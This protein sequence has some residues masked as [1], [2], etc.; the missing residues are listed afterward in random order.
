[1]CSPSR[2]HFPANE[3]KEYQANT[4]A[5][6][7]ITPTPQKQIIR[8]LDTGGSFNTEYN[9]PNNGVLFSVRTE[10]PTRLIFYYF[11]ISGLAGD[12]SGFSFSPRVSSATD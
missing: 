10:I 12:R 3:N 6:G 5:D 7:K 1:M 11:S 8:N 2:I 4:G 9:T